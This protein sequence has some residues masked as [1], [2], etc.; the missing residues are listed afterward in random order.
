MNWRAIVLLDDPASDAADVSASLAAGGCTD[1]LVLDARD[2]AALEQVRGLLERRSAPYQRDGLEI[3]FDARRV[4]VHG[5]DVA[6]TAREFGVLAYLAVN[7]G[8]IRTVGEIFE[9]VWERP[10]AGQATYLWTYVRR[11]RRKIEADPAQPVHVLSRGGVGYFMP[12]AD[13]LL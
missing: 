2:V 5:S 12:L 9:A 7:A 6:L 10:Y 4:R 1:L 13:P 3:D 8:K 11:L